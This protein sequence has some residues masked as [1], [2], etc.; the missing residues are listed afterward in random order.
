M[1]AWALPF[2]QKVSIAITGA[3]RAPRLLETGQ[4]LLRIGFLAKCLSILGYLFLKWE[5]VL[6]ANFFQLHQERVR[7]EKP[8]EN[9]ARACLLVEA[10]R[11]T[12]EAV[13]AAIGGTNAPK[14]NRTSTLYQTRGYVY[15]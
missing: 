11:S 8:A 4:R 14:R 9:L 7:H 13:I 5:S 12:R 10:S 3:A 6:M 2:Y 15:F 1:R